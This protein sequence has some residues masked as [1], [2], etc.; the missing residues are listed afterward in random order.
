MQIRLTAE[1]LERIL[2]KHFS[3]LGSDRHPVAATE[4]MA[5]QLCFVDPELK[6]EVNVD[7]IRGAT[8]INGIPQDLPKVADSF[9]AP[10]A[11]VE[12]TNQSKP[13]T[14]EHQESERYSEPNTK[15]PESLK[16]YSTY[17]PGQNS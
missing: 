15:E 4:D 5:Y 8:Y 12:T 9:G 7:L 2:F 6:L 3:D 11:S 16:V 17:Q 10:P 1:E 13:Q 14:T